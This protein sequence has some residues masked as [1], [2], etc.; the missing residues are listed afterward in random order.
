MQAAVPIDS[1][2][3]AEFAFAHAALSLRRDEMIGLLDGA[4]SCFAPPAPSE[5]QYRQFAEYSAYV[6][7]ANAAELDRAALRLTALL[8]Q[9]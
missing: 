6:Q 8:V 4:M 9:L 5:P 2:L 7:R 1:V 3:D